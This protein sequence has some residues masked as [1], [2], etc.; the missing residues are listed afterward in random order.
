MQ[1]NVSFLHLLNY[2]VPPSIIHLIGHHHYYLHFFFLFV[3]EKFLKTEAIK[4]FLHSFYINVSIHIYLNMCSIFGLLFCLKSGHYQID[5]L[6]V[7]LFT[8]FSSL[9]IMNQISICHKLIPS[10]EHVCAGAFVSTEK[11]Q[12]PCFYHIA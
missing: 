2:S 6:T 1:W 11:I 4:L 9:F 10:L 7:V 12:T 3:P 5:P 8:K